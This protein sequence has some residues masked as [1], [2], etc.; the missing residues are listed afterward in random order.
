MDSI[1]HGYTVATA[2]QTDQ[3]KTWLEFK[4]ERILSKSSTNSMHQY[5]HIIDMI[6]GN[7]HWHELIQYKW[8]CLADNIIR[9]QGTQD[10][11]QQ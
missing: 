6:E 7:R 5:Q 2:T 3:N 9:Q 4:K 8:R 1:M 10:P 11:V